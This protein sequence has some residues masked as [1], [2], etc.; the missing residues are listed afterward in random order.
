MEINTREEN[1]VVVIVLEGEVDISTTD[2]M[3]GKFKKLIEE[4]K[5]AIVVNLASV[6]YI[7]SSGLGM[8]VETMQEMGKYG[9]ELKLSGL[10]DDV[11]KVFELT[12]LSNFFSI[13]AE[14]KEAIGSFK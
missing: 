9:G 11:K 6:P 10:T 7:D 2:L 3:R 5:K 8:F 13:F 4:K 1:G 14:E 12:R